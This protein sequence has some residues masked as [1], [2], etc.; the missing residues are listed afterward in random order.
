MKKLPLLCALLF[1]FVVS[2]LAA[3][4]APAVTSNPNAPAPAVT[5]TSPGAST[6]GAKSGHKRH[7]K[8]HRKKAGNPAATPAGGAK[9]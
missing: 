2:G 9:P 7:R 3:A 8:H 4:D 1:A 5:G 6:T